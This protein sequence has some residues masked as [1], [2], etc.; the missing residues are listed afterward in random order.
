MGEAWKIGTN[1]MLSNSSCSWVRLE[2]KLTLYVGCDKPNRC[3]WTCSK[4]V[5]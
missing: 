5:Q 3:E 4:Q 2:K 1:T